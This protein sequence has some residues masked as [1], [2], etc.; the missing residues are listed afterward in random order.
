MKRGL[1]GGGCTG[2]PQFLSGLPS[3]IRERRRIP[4]GTGSSSLGS[5]AGDV[6]AAGTP[7][8]VQS[9][10]QR[11]GS[12]RLCAGLGC[13]WNPTP[14]SEG[15]LWVAA[16]PESHWTWRPFSCPQCPHL[17]LEGRER[18]PQAQTGRQSTE[19]PCR[20]GT[21]NTGLP[22][23]HPLKCPAKPLP[24]Q[25]QRACCGGHVAAS[26]RGLFK[27]T[28]WGAGTPKET[29]VI[30]DPGGLLREERETGS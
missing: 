26:S 13:W 17:P 16:P 3:H 22:V 21:Q 6:S 25:A 5:R 11:G 10:C 28:L 20:T 29:P 18:V 9:L 23:L 15:S 1:Q 7:Q 12:P 24:R 2:S 27:L 14:A 19:G 4:D 8:R 30:K